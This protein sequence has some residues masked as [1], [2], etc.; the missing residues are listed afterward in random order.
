MFFVAEMPGNK[1]PDGTSE[2]STSRSSSLESQLQQAWLQSQIPKVQRRSVTA[3]LSGLSGEKRAELTLNGVSGR[4]PDASG[5]ENTYFHKTRTETVPPEF[6]RRFAT[7]QL[8]TI[9]KKTDVPVPRSNSG[10]LPDIR[11]SPST[12]YS[13]SASTLFSSS[14]ELSIGTQLC[15]GEGVFDSVDFEGVGSGSAD[16]AGE[17]EP[18]AQFLDDFLSNVELEEEKCMVQQTTAYQAMEKEIADLL[19]A[20]SAVDG[21]CGSDDVDAHDRFWTN[22]AF[23]PN[24]ESSEYKTM[25]KEIA[26]L[27][28]PQSTI[29]DDGGCEVLNDKSNISTESPRPSEDEIAFMMMEGYT[30]MLSKHIQDVS[31]CSNVDYRKWITE[32]DNIQF[33]ESCRSFLE[34]SDSEASSATSVFDFNVL[35]RSTGR[36][37]LSAEIPSVPLPGTSITEL[38]YRYCQTPA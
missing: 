5:A 25:A 38:L 11:N 4:S 3:S 24:E 19:A 36:M 29:I 26:D 12:S 9:S 22:V 7:P 17:T 18:L 2:G 31:I 34:V 21:A 15:T 6:L 8:E 28:S 23:T 20:D 33:D 14:D 13:T 35:L 30:S 32:S 10:P 27:L 1:K 37:N 16:L